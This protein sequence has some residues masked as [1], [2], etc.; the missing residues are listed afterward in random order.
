[1]EWPL[2]Y[3]ICIT[4]LCFS[5]V[6]RY[7]VRPQFVFV[8]KPWRSISFQAIRK[9]IT[10]FWCFFLPLVIQDQGL[11]TRE[12]STLIF[13]SCEIAYLNQLPVY[14]PGLKNFFKPFVLPLP[15]AGL[16]GTVHKLRYKFLAFFD[17]LPPFVDSF[18]L[19]KVDISELPTYPPLLVNVRFERPLF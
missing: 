19:I 13:I 4:N 18:Y 9:K 16:L 10:S 17:H 14:L 11:I 2:S 8:R 6:S 7:R 3:R 5:F 1:M 12:S 15:W